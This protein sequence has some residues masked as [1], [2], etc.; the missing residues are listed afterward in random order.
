MKIIAL[1]GKCDAGK[2]TTLRC[3]IQEMMAKGFAPLGE[4]KPGA[5]TRIA[6]GDDLWVLFEKNDKKIA[7]TTR[8]DTKE[9]IEKDLNEA[10]K[11][12]GGAVDVFV[13]AAHTYGQTVDFIIKKAGYLNSYFFGKIGTDDLSLQTALNSRDVKMLLRFIGDALAGRI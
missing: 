11:H 6:A 7:V 9:N 10:A 12:A 1:Q 4:E 5:I 3:L 2:S 8:G 13:C